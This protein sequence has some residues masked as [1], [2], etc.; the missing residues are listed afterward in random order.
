MPRRKKRKP[1]PTGWQADPHLRKLQRRRARR[2]TQRQAYWRAKYERL[3]RIK[4]LSTKHPNSGDLYTPI[5]SEV[6]QLLDRMRAEHGSWRAVSQCTYHGDPKDYVK[7]RVI[8][9]IYTG[10]YITVAMKTLDRL[11]TDTQIGNIQNFLW[12][13]PEDLIALG[14]WKDYLPP[15]DRAKVEELKA[16]KPGAR[17]MVKYKRE[18]LHTGGSDAA[19]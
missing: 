14:L 13:T 15:E 6:V 9:R 18:D 7:L 2:R 10:H 4:P 19:S 1:K 3:G 16:S 8:R 12:F 11:V 17:G 5:T